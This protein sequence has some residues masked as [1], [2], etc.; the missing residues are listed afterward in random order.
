MLYAAFGSPDDNINVALQ[1]GLTVV[2][3]HIEAEIVSGSRISSFDSCRVGQNNI[4]STCD[5]QIRKWFGYSDHSIIDRIVTA[6]IITDNHPNGELL[7][8]TG[9][10]HGPVVNGCSNGGTIDI[11]HSHRTVD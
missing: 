2:I 1:V 8:I 10:V 7:R 3:L 6:I 11:A 9:D 4:S 5:E